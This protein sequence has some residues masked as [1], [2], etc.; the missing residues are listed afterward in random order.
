MAGEFE[1]LV[2][3]TAGTF[4]D[5]IPNVKGTFDDLL[6]MKPRL[7]IS[8]PGI[9]TITGKP[10]TGFESMPP[11]NVEPLSGLRPLEF[12]YSP[13]TA[14]RASF[15]A[16]MK[17]KIE[18]ASLAEQ[19]EEMLTWF[20]AGLGEWARPI[21]EAPISPTLS[22]ITGHTGALGLIEN[23]LGDPTLP[24]MGSTVPGIA[25]KIAGTQKLGEMQNI[26]RGTKIGNITAER[27]ITPTFRQ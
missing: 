1:D 17:K 19:A 21:G 8:T 4:D 6:P 16:G 14:G 24:F 9:S 27:T 26:L 10:T 13:L 25:K 12:L 11:V 18:G 7:P 22:S 5:L 15:M 23:V 3:K 20:G 2:P